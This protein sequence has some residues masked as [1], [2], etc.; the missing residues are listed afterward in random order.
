VK[1]NF[2]VERVARF[3]AK[4]RRKMSEGRGGV[5]GHFYREKTTAISLPRK[6]RITRKVQRNLFRIPFVFRG[7][8]QDTHILVVIDF[9]ESHCKRAKLRNSG[10]L[11]KRETIGRSGWD[12]RKM[13]DKK[14]GNRESR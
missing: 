7:H 3:A 13:A 4:E 5:V 11:G 6:T 14:M 10:Q 9:G 1:N 8:I 2:L 12:D